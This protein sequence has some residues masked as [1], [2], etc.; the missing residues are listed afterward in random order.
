MWEIREWLFE[1]QFYYFMFISLVVIFTLLVLYL[2]EKLESMSKG[3]CSISGYWKGC[4]SFPLAV[5]WMMW[6]T[7]GRIQGI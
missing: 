3:I 2:E 5:F 7:S 6:G 4:K 1:N